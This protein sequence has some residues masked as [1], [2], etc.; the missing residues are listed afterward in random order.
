MRPRNVTYIAINLSVL[1]LSTTNYGENLYDA[2]TGG[3]VFPVISIDE[4]TSYFGRFA[5]VSENPLIWAATDIKV[6]T[7]QSRTAAV[8]DAE[9]VLLWVPEVNV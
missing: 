2:A 1:L 3:L 8:Y 6:T 7:A 9:T 5:R 4:S